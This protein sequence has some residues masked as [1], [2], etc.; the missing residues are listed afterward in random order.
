MTDLFA[1]IPVRDFATALPWYERLLGSAPAFY[2][3]ETE[4]VWMLAEHQYLYIVQRPEH[5]GHSIVT[6][7]VDDLET[8]VAAIS[9]R[10]IAMERRENF[11][12]R[13]LKV[14]FRDPDGNEVAFGGPDR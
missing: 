13:I 1:G 14:T 10:G 9:D 2:P 11:P 12:N 3:H 8:L 4:A 5:A 7:M 6:V